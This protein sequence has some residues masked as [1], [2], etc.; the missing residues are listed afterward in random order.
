MVQR[1]GELRGQ[2]V[3]SLLVNDSL[4]TAAAG[5]GQQRE[6]L[7]EAGLRDQLVPRM[8]KTLTM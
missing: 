8:L 7:D 4:F 5:F 1:V 3:P 6:T 2:L